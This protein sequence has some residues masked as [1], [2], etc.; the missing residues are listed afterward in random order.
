ML[1][2]GAPVYLDGFWQSER[3]FLDCSDIVRRE[4]TA[5]DPFDHR[6]RSRGGTNRC[7]QRGVAA[8]CRGEHVRAMT[9][10]RYHGIVRRN[11]IRM[12]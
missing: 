8:F 1:A 9:T 4:L 10:N 12:L 11:I 2:L 5:T 3:Y 6:E 7:S